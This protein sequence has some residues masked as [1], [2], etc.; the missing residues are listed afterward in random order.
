MGIVQALLTGISAGLALALLIGPAFFALLQT[1]VKNGFR[2][3]ILM[4][5]G[6]FLSDVVCVALAYV[7]A[8]QFFSNPENK[9]LIGVLGGTIL[10]IFGTYNASQKQLQ[11]TSDGKK[12]MSTHSALL[13][14][15]FL[16]LLNFFRRQ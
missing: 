4:A 5:T 15:F 3:G 6:I 11:T 16:N 8:S 7:G 13:Q 9:I 1:S 14:G 2:S 10:I 12:T